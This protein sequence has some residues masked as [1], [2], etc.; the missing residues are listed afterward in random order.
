M[1]QAN[2]RMTTSTTTLDKSL[3]DLRREVN[4]LRQLDRSRD[5]DTRRLTSLLGTSRDSLK[6]TE[7]FQQQ[8]LDRLQQFEVS[9]AD[10][11][12]ILRTNV[13]RKIQLQQSGREIVPCAGLFCKVSR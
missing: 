5:Y 4:D 6:E 8:I 7:Q 3:S 2:Q 13:E 12:A 10:I 11:N 1:L 9:L